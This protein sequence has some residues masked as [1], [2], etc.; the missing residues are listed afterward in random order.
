MKNPKNYHPVN[1]L[2]TF[3]LLVTLITAFSAAKQAVYGADVKLE[4]VRAVRMSFQTESG[5][6]YRILTST[7]VDS[8]TWVALGDPIEGT[9]EVYTFYRDSEIPAETFFKVEELGS[10]QPT[11]IGMVF[12]S[13][14]S[15]DMGDPFGDASSDE[16]PVHSVD[17]SGFNMDRYE[18][19]KALWDEVY[20]WATA[21]GYSFDH[22]GSGK[23]DHHPVYSVNWY[24]VVK[25]CNARSEKE[26]RTPAY[27]TDEGKTTVYR[28]GQVDIQNDWVN[29][30]AGYR[31]HAERCA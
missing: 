16:R 19:T 2:N 17:V 30:R 26:G 31:L 5:K 8:G 18:V 1:C 7:D 9:G 22:S 27:Y 25:W 28:N 13:A 23:A 6:Q 4:I 10:D 24:D 29:W 15:F 21:N 11:P 3:G 20:Q 12:I 14:G